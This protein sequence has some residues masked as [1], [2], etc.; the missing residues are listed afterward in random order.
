MKSFLQNTVS[1]LLVA[2][3]AL[4]VFPILLGILVVGSLFKKAIGE[5]VL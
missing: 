1:V 5:K 4:G 2:F 3:F